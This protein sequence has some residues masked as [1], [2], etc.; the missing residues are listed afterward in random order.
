MNGPRPPPLLLPPLHRDALS[1]CPATARRSGARSMDI[2]DLAR[3][4]RRSNG[5]LASASAFPTRSLRR[6]RPAARRRGPYSGGWIISWR[7]SPELLDRPGRSG[8]RYCGLVGD[9]HPGSWATAPPNPVHRIAL[10]S[11]HRAPS[12][13][14]R[15]CGP[16]PSGFCALD[17][18]AG[19]DFA[20]TASQLA[21]EA[22]PLSAVRGEIDPRLSED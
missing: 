20:A 14:L 15:R 22:R 3:C 1:F 5:H 16:P 7:H 11:A 4:A 10:R 13:R 2:D 12:R 8:S 21:P 19:R 18:P 17:F 9:R 6:A